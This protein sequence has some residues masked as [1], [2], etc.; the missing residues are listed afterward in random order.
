[1][2][3]YLLTAHLTPANIPRVRMLS[4]RWGR[5]SLTRRTALAAASG[6][7]LPPCRKVWPQYLARGAKKHGQGER[8]D[9][10]R[11]YMSPRGVVQVTAPNGL[12]SAAVPAWGE[13]SWGCAGRL[14]G[15]QWEQPEITLWK[16]TYSASANAQAPVGL[17]P[18][19]LRVA[20]T[21]AS[22]PEYRVLVTTRLT[23]AAPP[24]SLALTGEP[25]LF[26]HPC[27]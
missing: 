6:F 24:P 7:P 14:T 19:A 16:G 18:R 26:S 1:M 3:P 27:E 23:W 15:H 5:T 25:E 11:P 17:V 4:R 8:L 20:W 22:A 21:P 12:G 2:L 13:E 10:P 9:R